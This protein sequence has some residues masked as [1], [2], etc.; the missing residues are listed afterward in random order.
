MAKVLLLVAVMPIGLQTVLAAGKDSS[1]LRRL[2]ERFPTTGERQMMRGV[3]DQGSIKVDDGVSRCA[4]CPSYTSYAGDKTGFAIDEII[5]GTFA[6]VHEQEV[7]LNMKG[8]EPQSELGG[9]MVLLRRTDAGWS[10]LHYQKGYRLRDCMKFPM[11]DERHSLFCNQSTVTRGGEIGQ[12]LWVS[13]TADEFQARLLLPWY[14]NVT[15][16]P[17]QLVT[18]FPARFQRS[19]FNQD[20]RN[21]L[22]ILFRIRK[23][24]IPEKYNGAIEAI[25]AGYEL[26]PPRLLGLVYL[27][28]GKSL[29]LDEGSSEAFA[30]INLLLEKYMPANVP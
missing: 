12:I 9:G 4:V 7:L 13:V 5:P 27:F 2:I 26:D 29:L 14:D 1:V 22:H 25:D 10:R 24:T 3:C 28:D 16:N 30:E 21:D 11:A 20:G 15:S 19:D 23:E 17:R 6:A 18:V 8:C